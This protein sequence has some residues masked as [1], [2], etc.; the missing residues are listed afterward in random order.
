MFN[1]WEKYQKTRG[2][3]SSSVCWNNIHKIHSSCK[4]IYYRKAK[5]EGWRARS[6][7]KLLQ[8]N[9]QY[10]ILNGLLSNSG[11]FVPKKV[12]KQQWSW[13]GVKR[14]VDLCAAP[15]SWSQVLSRELY[16]KKQY[17]KHHHPFFCQT[18][19]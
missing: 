2:F 13:I 15:G 6:A 14:A 12:F 7:F 4:D 8:I 16:E 17:H 9:E 10:G 1:K 3:V 11:L 5:E 19:C 18:F